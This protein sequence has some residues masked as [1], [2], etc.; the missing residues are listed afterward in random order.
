VRYLSLEDVQ[1]KPIEAA[2]NGLLN[3]KTKAFNGPHSRQQKTRPASTEH[4]DVDD[5]AF[6]DPNLNLLQGYK[7]QQR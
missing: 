3:V 6:P 1:G 7:V 5:P 4:V 2:D